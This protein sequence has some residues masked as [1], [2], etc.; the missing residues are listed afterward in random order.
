MFLSSV[1][2]RVLIRRSRSLSPHRALQTSNGEASRF[3]NLTEVEL[4]RSPVT[5][6]SRRSVLNEEPRAQY[7]QLASRWR[8]NLE[9][10]RSSWASLTASGRNGGGKESSGETVATVGL[11]SLAAVALCSNEDSEDKAKALLEAV[12]STNT[13]EMSRQ[14][15]C[16]DG[17]VCLGETDLMS[18]RRTADVLTALSEGSLLRLLSEGADPNSRHR[19]GWTPLM[20]AAINKQHHM[21]QV[22]LE[23]GADPNLGDEFS[24]VIQTAREKNTHSLEEDEFNSRLSSRASFR[25]CSALHYAALADDAES[26]R[27]LLGA[28]SWVKRLGLRATGRRYWIDSGKS[29]DSS[30]SGQK[31]VLTSTVLWKHK[32]SVR[33]ALQDLIWHTIAFAGA[34]PSLRNEL[35][36]TPLQYARDGEVSRE[37]KEAQ[38]TFAEAQRKREAEQRRKFPLELRLK[39]HIIGQEGA[40]NTVGSAIRRKENGWYDEEHPL[41]FLF[42]GSSGIGKTELAKQVAR[43]LHK[44][45][46]KGFIRMDM[47]EFQEKHEVSKFIGSPPGYVGHEEGGILTRSLSVC[48]DAVVLF[49]EVDKAHPDVLTI[50]LQLFDEGRLT[51]GKGKTIECKNAIFIMTS[52]IASEEISQHALQ[53]RQEA[54]EQTKQRLAQ[55]LKDVQKRESVTISSSFKEHVIR[56]ILKA[57]FR[58]DEFLGRINEMV[59]FLPFSSDELTQ[60]VNKELE[61]WAKKAKQRHDI[62]LI[63]DRAVLDLLAEGY[64][65]H[66]GARSIKHQVERSVLSQLSSA[67]EQEL[68]PDGSTLRLSVEQQSN[69]SI[70]RL[71]LM[72]KENNSRKL[73]VRSPLS[74]E[75]VSHIHIQ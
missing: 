34:D 13:K 45:L 27:M 9:A 35:G 25:G 10:R 2:A 50:M 59:Y 65:L 63:W 53:L 24:S 70:L 71:E 58:R 41:V 42:L 72:D 68:L 7:H 15:E 30:R 55:N 17:S 26:V 62:T 4:N 28:G 40:I 22:L 49:D 75:D 11:L 32:L 44:D 43:Y 18:K 69:S 29:T 60:L 56:P 31:A 73:T 66:Y 61:F 16:A 36:H 38:K 20:L 48:P 1:P 51:D 64:N 74:T 67:Y 5:R 12:R 3:R 23:A 33:S 46:K 52:N 8:V 21:L 39:E 54:Q 19:L 57:H 47:S 37:L 6:C 14:A